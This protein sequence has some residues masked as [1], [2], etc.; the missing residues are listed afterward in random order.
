MRKI[1]LTPSV[2]IVLL[3][4]SV[5]SRLTFGQGSLTPPGPPAPS[6]KTLDQ[7]E[8]RIDV[9]NA[10]ASAVTTSDPNYHYIITQPGSYYLSA[11]ITATKS[12]A[13]KIAAPDVTLDLCG[14]RI[15]NGAG[16][17]TTEGIEVVGQPRA[18]IFNGVITGFAYG[19]GVDGNSHAYAIR[20]IAVSGCTFRSIIAAGKGGLFD[21]C[22][23]YNNTGE[24]GITAGP[25]STVTN[26]TSSSNSLTVAGIYAQSGS[27]IVN[28]SATTNSSGA[29][30]VA[31][32][33]CT[34]NNCTASGNSAEGFAVNNGCTVTNCTARANHDGFKCNNYCHVFHNT[35]SSNTALGI[36]YNSFNRIDENSADGNSTG[37][38]T[39]SV[40]G[41]HNLIIRNFG[42]LYSL[43]PSD[44]WGPTLAGNGSINTTNPWTNFIH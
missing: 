30:F 5:P 31:D 22:R 18:T 1:S 40:G 33:G 38:Y 12:H 4:L 23:V 43:G 34:F 3:L 14:F 28:C 19:I 16:A 25:S 8:P 13:I 21:G 39:S 26:C 41:G 11:N 20:N 6:M 36:F 27:T 17:G 10:P 9:R 7:I 44:G 35:A 29:G 37:D 42:Y 32:D 15:T 2:L 24:S